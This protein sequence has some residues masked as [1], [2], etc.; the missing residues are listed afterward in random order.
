MRNGNGNCPIDKRDGNGHARTVNANQRQPDDDTIGCRYENQAN[1]SSGILDPFDTWEPT[2]PAKEATEVLS[3]SSI[4]PVSE[5]SAPFPFASPLPEPSNP[6][7]PP[8]A[9]PVPAQSPMA[10]QKA[11]RNTT[12]AVYAVGAI[13]LLAVF[14][15]VGY[16]MFG[17]A[18]QQPTQD[19]AGTLATPTPETLIANTD[20]PTPTPETNESAEALVKGASPRPSTTPI[21]NKVA[22]PTPTNINNPALPH[23]SD[24]STA[25]SATNPTTPNATPANTSAPTSESAASLISQGNKFLAGKQ[26]PDAIAAYQKARR[27][28]PSNTDLHYLLGSAYHQQGQLNEALAQYRQCISGNY[29]AVA[30]NHVKNL[31]K[32]LAK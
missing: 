4:P 29:A 31:E 17:P 25:G 8:P 30:A 21:G 14:S 27:L 19:I 3:A 15:W 6:A 11:A 12:I 13:L 26:F 10:E 5:T 20:L 16:R 23:N 1:Q 18:P 28:D 24:H 2:S 7:V 9:H 22:A 32:K